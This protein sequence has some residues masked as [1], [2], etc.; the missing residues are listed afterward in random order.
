M[1]F[2]FFYT[3]PWKLHFVM[4]PQVKTQLSL[5]FKNFL[6]VET[7]LTVA[8]LRKTGVPKIDPP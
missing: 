2:D 6:V 7:H 3:A 4:F 5:S 8:W 1:M